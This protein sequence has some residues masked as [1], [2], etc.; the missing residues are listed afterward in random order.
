ME[1][2]FIVFTRELTLYNYGKEDENDEK[3]FKSFEKQF[4][5]AKGTYCI[6]LDTTRTTYVYTIVVK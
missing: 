4:E 1:F 2:S 3:E 6:H 5:F